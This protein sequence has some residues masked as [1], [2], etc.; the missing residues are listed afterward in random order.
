MTTGKRRANWRTEMEAQLATERVAWEKRI[1]DGIDQSTHTA[2]TL[3]DYRKSDI[4]LLKIKIRKIV[5]WQYA[6]SGGVVALIIVAV[7]R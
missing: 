4:S 1:K 2:I 6:L 5:L 7:F 3:S